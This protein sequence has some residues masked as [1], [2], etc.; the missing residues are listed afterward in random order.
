MKKPNFL[1]CFLVRFGSRFPFKF[2]EQIDTRIDAEQVMK[3]MKRYVKMV[4][5]ST[6]I[7]IVSEVAFRGNLSFLKM[8]MYENHM[9]H[10]VEYVWA[11]VHEKTRTRN[12]RRIW[13]TNFPKPYKKCVGEVM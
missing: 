7:L 8:W 13:K 1:E 3:I 5:K 11:T 9:I 4:L 2:N 12:N 10:A 6:R